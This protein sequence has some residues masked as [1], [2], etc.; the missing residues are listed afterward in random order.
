MPVASLDLKKMPDLL[1]NAL[2]NLL[3]LRDIPTRITYLMQ[4]HA[5][6][7]SDFLPFNSGVRQKCIILPLLFSICMFLTLGSI[8]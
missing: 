8:V 1:H 6:G 2:R 5:G 3:A 7:V 4:V